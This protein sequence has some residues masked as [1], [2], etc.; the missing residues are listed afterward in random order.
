[1]RPS[2]TCPACG[3]T[4]YHPKDVENGYCV[5][6]HAFTGEQ[7]PAQDYLPVRGM[8]GFWVIVPDSNPGLAWSGSRWMPHYNGVPTGYAQIS[9]FKSR[10]EALDYI[11]DNFNAF[12][13]PPTAG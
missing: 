3:K 6:C 12:Y 1:M 9:N 11:R 13:P 7:R 8:L 5:N 4:S 2:I 10:E